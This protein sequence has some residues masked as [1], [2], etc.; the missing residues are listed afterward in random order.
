MSGLSPDITELLKNDLREHGLSETAIDELMAYA[1]SQAAEM[2]A[3]R[4]QPGSG[5]SVLNLP[6]ICEEM[7]MYL[8]LKD[9]EGFSK[10]M[11]RLAIRARDTVKLAELAADVLRS[12][13]EDIQAWWD[14]PCTIC[15]LRD[16]H[17]H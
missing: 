16:P 2:R 6:E 7:G 17:K 8:R 3:A 11:F 15:G 1:E 10:M 12:M 5:I 9:E 14:Q 4:E 13:P